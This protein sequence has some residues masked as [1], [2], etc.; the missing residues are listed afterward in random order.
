MSY[1][2]RKFHSFG[3]HSRAAADDDLVREILVIATS[4]GQIGE[5]TRSSSARQG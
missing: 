5:I 4:D 3:K 2:S 1:L